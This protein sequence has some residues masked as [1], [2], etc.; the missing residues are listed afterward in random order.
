MQKNKKLLKIS[1]NYID[2]FNK[3]IHDKPTQKEAR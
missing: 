3:L 2:K 1:D